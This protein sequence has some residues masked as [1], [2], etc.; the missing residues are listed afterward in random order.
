DHYQPRRP[1]EAHWHVREGNQLVEESRL[2]DPEVGEREGDFC[3]SSEPSFSETLVRVETQRH[4]RGSRE[5]VPP[6]TTTVSPAFLEPQ[7]PPATPGG[8]PRTAAALKELHS[9]A[10]LPPHVTALLTALTEEWPAKPGRPNRFEVM[11]ALIGSYMAGDQAL[12]E[13]IR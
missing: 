8:S 10:N 13:C 5:T 4:F 1:Q 12:R 3:S 6:I 7:L 9:M 11:R 2:H